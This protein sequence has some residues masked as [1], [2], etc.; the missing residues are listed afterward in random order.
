MKY[1]NIKTGSILET[2]AVIVSENWKAIEESKREEKVAPAQKQQRQKRT[3][4]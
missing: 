2:P 4:K 1:I 3:K